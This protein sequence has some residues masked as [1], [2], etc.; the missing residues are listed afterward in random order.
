M[1]HYLDIPYNLRLFFILVCVYCLFLFIVLD[2]CLKGTLS[3]DC[4]TLKSP[5]GTIRQSPNYSFNANGTMSP[6]SVHSILFDGATEPTLTSSPLISAQEAFS[7]L[8]RPRNLAEK[9]R[10]NAG[11]VVFAV[12]I[13]FFM[14]VKLAY[15]MELH[16]SCLVIEA[17][18]KV[19]PVI[20]LCS[21]FWCVNPFAPEISVT[22]MFWSRHVSVVEPKG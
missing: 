7:R 5:F 14:H 9:A 19:G 4:G 17:S 6:G 20:V 10:I 1:I 15:V 3:R 8:Y 21:L 2:C 13:F 11:L 22:S 12:R 18:F 16:I